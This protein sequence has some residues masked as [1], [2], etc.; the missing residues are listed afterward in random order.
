MVNNHL[1]GRVEP[2]DKGKPDYHA[3][4]S[5]LISP[6]CCYETHK[7]VY[8]VNKVAYCYIYETEFTTSCQYMENYTNLLLL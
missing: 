2:K 5:N 4:F 8:T 3:I 1:T 7:V 6:C